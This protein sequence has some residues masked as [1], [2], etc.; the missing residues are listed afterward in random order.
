MKELIRSKVFIT[1]IFGVFI[2]NGCGQSVEDGNGKFTEEIISSD[3]YN[4]ELEGCGNLYFDENVEVKL[5]RRMATTTYNDD[6]MTI[7]F[8][9]SQ[10][11]DVEN[12]NIRAV[13]NSGDELY[14]MTLGELSGI[15][16]I[17]FKTT[18]E[19]A[20]TDFNY[21]M[22]GKVFLLDN[23]NI[24]IA[25]DFFGYV[26]TIQINPYTKELINHMDFTEIDTG[27]WRFTV[28]KVT[29]T[30][31]IFYN[32]EGGQ[33]LLFNNSTGEL[34]DQTNAPGC[35][36][37]SDDFSMGKIVEFNGFWYSVTETG[38]YRTVKNEFEWEC[39]VL[40]SETECFN[41]KGVGFVDLIIKSETEIYVL[42]SSN[43]NI[44]G[45]QATV[46]FVKFTI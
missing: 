41:Y 30:N 1:I 4:P 24:G 35:E 38:I 11:F 7:Y 34:E 2:L 12:S 19:G 40:A 32:P 29:N 13:S 23:G 14:E 39:L 6:G 33:I 28:M 5:N 31:T 9:P 27:R 20:M 22:E 37:E 43:C 26:K 10:S 21:L 44:D 8:T 17:D 25:L 46:S 15:E 16:K 45:T 42:L 18:P 3:Q 36:N